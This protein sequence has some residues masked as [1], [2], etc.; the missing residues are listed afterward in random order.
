MKNDFLNGFVSNTA[1]AGSLS[2]SLSS[3]VIDSNI[4]L[5]NV[6]ALSFDSANVM[7]DRVIQTLA[8]VTIAIDQRH[9]SYAT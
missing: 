9:M 5:T 6:I 2:A 8:S 7:I 4:S 1:S 3:L